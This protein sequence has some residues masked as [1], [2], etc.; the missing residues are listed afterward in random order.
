[1]KDD[2]GPAFPQNYIDRGNGMT[3]SYAFGEGGI[4][5]RDW[6]AGQALIGWLA[7]FAG[8]SA[9]HIKSSDIAAEC[10]DFADAVLKE[11]SK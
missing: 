10:Y 4:S 8:D 6:F 3:P 5:I 1:M 7:S 9:P 11:R 2:G